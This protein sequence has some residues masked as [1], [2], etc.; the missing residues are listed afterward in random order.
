MKHGFLGGSSSI[1]AMQRV[2]T[3]KA[4]GSRPRESTN[5]S[6]KHVQLTELATWSVHHVVEFAV[7]VP[8]A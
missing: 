3:H 7:D 6:Q 4:A 2:N 8:Y 1:T 5:D